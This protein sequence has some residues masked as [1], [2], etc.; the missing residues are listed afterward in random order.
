MVCKFKSASKMIY[1]RY[2]A[3]AVAVISFKKNAKP[4]LNVR[5]IDIAKHIFGHV[6]D[7]P[8]KGK[9]HINRMTQD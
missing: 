2:E 1:D 6:F 4:L 9:M 5:R 8:P 3:R 7:V